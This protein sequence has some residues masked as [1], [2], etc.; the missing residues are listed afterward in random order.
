[1]SWQELTKIALLGTENTTFSNETLQALQAL[2]IDVS[3]EAPLVLA[4]G[5][6]LYAQLKK[7][8]FRLE[9]FT[10]EL[11]KASE[12]SGSKVCSIHSA[13]HLHL[14]LGGAFEK[15]LPEFFEHLTKNKKCLPPE[16]LPG[17]LKRPDIN[18]W[19]DDLQEALGERGR[20]LLAQHPDWRSMVEKPEGDWYTGNREQRLRL[21]AHL[22][23]HDPTTALELVES[24][25]AEE[26]YADKKAFLIILRQTGLSMA[27]EPFLEQC[28]DDSRKEVR[29]TVVHVL[30]Y[31]PG[32][33]LTERMYQRALE[34]LQ[35]DGKHL[36]V[37]IPEAPDAA[38]ERDGVLKIDPKWKGGAKAGYLGQVVS[39]VPPE[40]WEVFFKK[41]PVDI[42]ALFAG[43]DW[44]DTLLLALAASAVRLHDA[45]WVDVLAVYWL[46]TERQ[47]LW[48][49][50]TVTWPL[51]KATSAATIN[52]LAMQY[53]EQQ[54]NL[55]GEH[56]AVYRLLQTSEQPW[57]DK[58]TMLIIRLLQE[59]LTKAARSDWQ[60]FHNKEYLK[61]IALRCN[62][63]LF[64]VLQKGWNN[65]V[66]LWGFW[67]KPL[68]EMLNMVLFRRE[69]RQEL[70]K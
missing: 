25:W 66:P 11:P 4:E 39:A 27:D 40:R 55:P 35:W 21:L 54:K 13:H 20:W 51:L 69:M 19:R 33:R 31:L 18:K 42:V 53:L 8:G 45:T 49:S 60:S 37:N 26:P 14:I 52:R 10:G 44:P 59:W 50:D 22:R 58:L 7:A 3:K 5:A 38:A 28:L 61:L 64:D 23:H 9:A 1:M 24:T 12:I 57:E 29:L 48:E 47:S 63:D 32:A 41:T 17:L 62:P 34:C 15:V 2:G 36:K 68:E 67:E 16:H 46:H 43:T 70:E 56:A 65:T 30:N 6:A